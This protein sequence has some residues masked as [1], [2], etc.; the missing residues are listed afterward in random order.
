M[1]KPISDT[2]HFKI[3]QELRVRFG[4]FAPRQVIPTVRELSE[5][6]GVA[7]G[8]IVK[9]L[10]AL[11]EE[12]VIERPAGKM[13]LVVAEH[14]DHHVRRIAIVRPDW[15]SPDYDSIVREVVLAGK[16]R[17]WGF[18]LHSYGDLN[19]LDMGR[20][21]T[22]NDGVVLLPT[23]GDVPEHLRKVLQRP[24]KPIVAVH[25]PISGEG[26]STVIVDERQC[27]RLAVD[28]L[29]GLGHRKILGVLS[30]THLSNQ[31]KRI[32]GWRERME[33]SGFKGDLDALLVDCDHRVGEFSVSRAYEVFAG[34]AARTP[35]GYSAV[36][37]D[38][39]TGAL[40]GTRVMRE[41]G[42]RIPE[43]VSVVAFSGAGSIASYL[44]PPLTAVEVDARTYG[45]A[46]IEELERALRSGFTPREVYVE[47]KLK[48]RGTT[49]QA[50]GEA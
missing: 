17:D 20:Y 41:R 47:P 37:F 21:F 2:K 35:R 27:G 15:P 30:V 16:R 18:C 7:Q 42:I 29:A 43:D 11:R 12:G 1:P 50:G 19:N 33:A 24:G 9:V 25:E 6:M 45:E 36:F 40:A 49:R 22:G 13:R 26:V 44:N 31:S 34:W 32:D 4:G 48:V 5:E 28:Y 14:H 38:S 10:G 39:W 46:V 3:T 8:T 23:P